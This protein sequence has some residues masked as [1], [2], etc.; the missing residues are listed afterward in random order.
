[1]NYK[2]MNNAI[3]NS[4]T[5]VYEKA[6]EQVIKTFK[7]RSDARNFMRSMNLGGAF[8]GWTPSFF[9]IDVMKI[10]NSTQESQ[11]TRSKKSRRGKS[12]KKG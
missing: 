9:L 11:K 5:D 12:H 3:D 4:C 2:L 7:D 8:D 10:L 6:T 1:M